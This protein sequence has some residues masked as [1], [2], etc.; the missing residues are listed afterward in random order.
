MCLVGCQNGKCDAVLGECLE[1]I[2]ADRRFGQ[3]HA[4][5]FAP[6]VMHKISHAPGHLSAAV[7]R[8]G[9][10]HDEMTVD[11]GNGGAMPTE[12]LA[13]LVVGCNDALVGVV[14]V[15]RQPAHQRRPNVEAHPSVVVADMADAPVG[16]QNPRGGV[17]RIALSRHTGVPIMIGGSARLWIDGVDP[18][19]FA[20]RLIKVPVHTDKTSQQLSLSRATTPL[21]VARQIQTMP[22][23]QTNQSADGIGVGSGA[24]KT[25][26][27]GGSVNSN[28]TG[29]SWSGSWR[30]VGCGCTPLPP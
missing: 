20:G 1:G 4:L 14:I 10:W 27:S 8:G 15:L 30:S 3:P 11:L 25:T 23:R 7:A 18:G 29:M 26:P 24:K 17:G 12:T 5:R 6:V 9:Q 19:V 2:G 28:E 21:A 13:A 22:Q 16:I